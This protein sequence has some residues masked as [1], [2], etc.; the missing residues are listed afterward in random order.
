MT[1]EGSYEW[2][3]TCQKLDDI[4][5]SLLQCLGNT[6]LHCDT[7]SNDL[8]EEPLDKNVIENDDVQLNSSL[9]PQHSVESRDLGADSASLQVLA[10]ETRKQF[11]PS[12]TIET[13]ENK[14]C[15]Q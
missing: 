1:N 12:E 4:A 14:K 10:E 6:K 7:E 3:W 5:Q 15:T 13:K 8:P 11:H 2:K 9:E